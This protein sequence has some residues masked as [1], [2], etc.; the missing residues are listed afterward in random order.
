MIEREK[1]IEQR[2]SEAYSRKSLAN[3]SRV[4]QFSEDWFEVVRMFLC[5]HYRYCYQL[6]IAVLV[7]LCIQHSAHL[8]N[9]NSKCWNIIE[10]FFLRF[11]LVFIGLHFFSSHVNAQSYVMCYMYMYPIHQICVCK[12][13]S[14]YIVILMRNLLFL[15]L[16]QRDF[17]NE[18]IV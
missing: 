15:K 3:T 8:D 5:D 9:F 14:F 16:K 13:N 17:K 7:C 10:F 18:Q 6:L 2:T 11:L 1:K 4:G 12:I